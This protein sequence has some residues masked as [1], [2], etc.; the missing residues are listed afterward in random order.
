MYLALLEYMKWLTAFVF[1]ATIATTGCNYCGPEQHAVTTS[2]SGLS[3]GGSVPARTVQYVSYRLTEP[4][5]AHDDFQFVFN[6]LE[7]STSGDGVAFTLS[8]TDAITQE[9]VILVLALPVALRQGD[10]Y[11]VGSTFSVDVTSPAR[12]GSWGAHDLAQSNKADVAFVVATYSF[13]PPVY[14]PNF[15]AVSSTGTIRVMNRTQG[16]VDLDL[17]LHFTDANGAVRTITG[18]AQ[19]NADKR[20]ALCN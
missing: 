16:H 15:R 1:A 3:M 17:D 2:S 6:T 11:S 7:G 14:T 5:A 12:D 20:A 19:A 9:N 10:V 4:P 18:P 13:P 8:G